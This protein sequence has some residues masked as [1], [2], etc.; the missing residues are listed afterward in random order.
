MNKKMI[1]LAVAAA[2]LAPAAMAQTANPVT[3]YGRVYVMFE[4]VKADGGAAAPIGTRNRVNNNGASLLGVRGTEDLGGGL[5]AFFQLETEFRPDQNDTTFATRNSGVGLQG[6]FGSVLLGRWDTPFKLSAAKYDVFGDTTI[7]GYT[8]VM[9][10]R[11]NFNRRDQNIIQYWSPNFSGVQFRVSYTANE[12]KSATAN[13]KVI[14]GNITY[15]KGPL[16]LAYGYEKHSDMLAQYTVNNTASSTSGGVAGARETGHSV[17]ASFT[18]GQF[19]VGGLMQRFI[20]PNVR[21]AGNTADS[22]TPTQKAAM[23]NLTYTEGKHQFVLQHARSK[24]GRTRLV[25]APTT[26]QP[27]SKANS[28]GYFY[29]FS[30]RTSFISTYTQIKNNVAGLGNFGANPFG[31][32]S[33]SNPQPTLAADQDPRGLAFGLRHTF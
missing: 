8:S 9:A 1:A 14:S 21:L 10:D 7:S 33:T 2:T 23:I 5:K 3:L 17:G 28:I 27:D 12:G 30:R 25:T 32:G 22:T 4:S 26:P 13:P 20:K 29:N 6:D 16:S 15:D 11:G 19:R 31:G 18:L 24:D